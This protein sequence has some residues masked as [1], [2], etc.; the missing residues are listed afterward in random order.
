MYSSPENL[1]GFV[2]TGAIVSA[3]LLAGYAKVE[4]ELEGFSDRFK[5]FFLRGLVAFILLA[6]ILWF[7]LRDAK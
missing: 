4:P 2:M 3:T 7:A 1:I 6:A 5:Y